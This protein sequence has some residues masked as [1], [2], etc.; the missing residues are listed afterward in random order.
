MDHIRWGVLSTA[1]IG[2]VVARACRNS[3]RARFVAVA[4]R[5]GQRA[6]QFADEEAMALSF[7][8]Y[9]ELLDSD[10][11][12]AVYIALPVSMHA[13]WTI[14]ALVAGKHVLC[15]KPL[16]A[17]SAQVEACF[18]AAERAGRACFEGL[19]YRHHPQTQLVA[20]MVSGGQI[21][22]L[23]F[24]R[25]TLSVAVDEA[26]IRRSLALDGGALNDLGCYCVSA[27]RLFAGSPLSI[28]AQQVIDAGGVDLRL[29]ATLRL[30]GDVLGQ[31]DV[32][33]DLPRR[34]VLELVGTTGRIVVRDPWLCRLPNIELWREG[35]MELVAID[36]DGA[37]A[38]AHDDS[39]AYR[40]EL[41]TISEAILA[42]DQTAFGRADAIE[43][44][45]VLEAIRDSARLSEP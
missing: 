20:R 21:G 10:A 19:M 11:V 17:S 32:G 6:R 12:D 45:R 30:P 33:L 43:Q 34:E 41:E 38:L 15:E 5:D 37:F 2:R 13:E 16:A 28:Q 9:E 42:G 27:V 24:V 40:I 39:D 29:A 23:A 25:A 35:E 14:K 31:F 3:P 4:S 26:D 44:A 18:D 36:P 8:S 22:P 1:R 7:G